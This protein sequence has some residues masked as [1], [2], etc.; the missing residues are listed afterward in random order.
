MKK[1]FFVIL[2]AVLLLAGCG[3]KIDKTTES[4]S[5]GLTPSSGASCAVS[6]AA[7]SGEEKLPLSD[8]E[9]TIETTLI[10]LKTQNMELLAQVASEKG[11][12]FSPYSYIDTGKNIIL[13]KEEFNAA[14]TGKT[15]YVRGIQDGKGDSIILTFKDYLSKFVYDVDFVNLG[16]KH[17][18]EN[19]TRGNSINNIPDVYSGKQTIEYYVP[20]LDPKYEGMDRR[21]L[22][23]VFDQENGDRKLIGVIHNQWTI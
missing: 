4:Q 20:G 6:G 15:Q 18:N 19:L 23:L 9:T 16:E 5:C 22:T 12:R 10:A 21:G 2:P 7:V 8:L 1:W 17:L 14:Y 11:I 3:V 13:K